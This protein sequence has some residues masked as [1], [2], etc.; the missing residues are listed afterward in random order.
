MQ[1]GPDR[2]HNVSGTSLQPKHYALVHLYVSC[3][4][5]CLKVRHLSPI[6]TRRKCVRK[7]PAYI[8]AH[9]HHIAV[10]MYKET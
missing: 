3:E 10:C 9:N 2:L 4:I 1:F 7:L 5:N 6:K 8:C